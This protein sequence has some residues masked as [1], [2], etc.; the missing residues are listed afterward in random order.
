[1]E[2]TSKRC[3]VDGCERRHVAR[4]MCGMHYQRWVKYADPQVRSARFIDH[5]APERA[6]RDCGSVFPATPEH[7]RQWKNGRLG[8]QCR[9]CRA[10]YQRERIARWRAEGRTCFVDGCERT[11]IQTFRG[12][13]VCAM[14]ASR[15]RRHGDFGSAE[16]MTR[17]AGSGGRTVE[18][19][20]IF[21]K[22]APGEQRLEHRRVMESV[23][24]RSL[25]NFENVHHKNGIPDDNR[26][27]NLELWVKAQPCGQRPD[28]LAEW[29]VEHYPALVEAALMRRT[30]LRFL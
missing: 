17:A 30:Q 14:H 18:G 11:I 16:P 28:D 27:E 9:R 29:V 2:Q 8:T 13:G 5:D 21:T 3:S 15:K 7:F 10:T 25:R 6:C 19:Y 1:M 24:G 12:G 26:P 22:R 4:G 23:L 20:V